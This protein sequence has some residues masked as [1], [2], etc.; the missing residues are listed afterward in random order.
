MEHI[1]RALN[2]LRSMRVRP[3]MYAIVRE[4]FLSEV[5]GILHVCVS[6]NL[7]DKLPNLYTKYGPARG[8]TILNMDKEVEDE[9]ARDVV[10]EAIVCIENDNS[11]VEEA[12][13]LIVDRP[14]IAGPWIP[15]RGKCHR[16]N[17]LG[18]P[19]AEVS[20]PEE[21]TKEDERLIAL[22]YQLTDK[23]RK[24]PEH[25]FTWKPQEEE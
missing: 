20:S 3:R 1:I 16:Y 24:L 6:Q 22:G 23:E 5:T 11:P 10:N 19:L 21:V 17:Q 2:I 4:A 18:H 14:M 7:H 9:W 8:N 25:F 13:R 15:F 12:W